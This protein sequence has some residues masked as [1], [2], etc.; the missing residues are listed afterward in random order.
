MARHQRNMSMF[1]LLFSSVLLG[2]GLGCSCP[3]ESFISRNEAIC[4][5]FDYPYIYN[6]YIGVVQEI[7]CKCLVSSVEPVKEISC[8]TVNGSFTVSNEAYLC[9]DGFPS[10]THYLQDCAAI[11]KILCKSLSALSVV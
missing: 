4:E 5:D 6:I 11:S 1:Q 9:E 2:F 8:I 10:G 3:W 7:Y